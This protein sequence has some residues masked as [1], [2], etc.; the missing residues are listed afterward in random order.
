MK[1]F[2]KFLLG[3]AAVGFVAGSLATVPSADAKTSHK[4]NFIEG[5]SGSKVIWEMSV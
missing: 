4:I 1:L 5:Y 3:L 2:K